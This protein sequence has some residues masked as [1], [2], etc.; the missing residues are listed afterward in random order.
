MSV[1]IHQSG[2]SWSLIGLLMVAACRSAKSWLLLLL[3]AVDR[4][5]A[6]GR[7]VVVDD[8]CGGGE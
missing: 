5:T 8:D 6:E 2:S 7:K 3:A 4:V 1:F